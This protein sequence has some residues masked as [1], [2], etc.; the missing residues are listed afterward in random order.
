MES[1]R[2]NHER[3]RLEGSKQCRIQEVAWLRPKKVQSVALG[4]SHALVVT[5]DQSIYS[6]G[7][8]LQAMGHPLVT[9]SQALHI[10]DEALVEA[11]YAE[12][13][14]MVPA[15]NGLTS[16]DSIEMSYLRHIGYLGASP[17]QIRRHASGSVI[18]LVLD[19]SES[20]TAGYDVLTPLQY[21]R[22][23]REQEALEVS[24]S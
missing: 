19:A 14:L 13:L 23:L 16:T 11:A 9:Q 10:T 7:N 24:D 3:G 8:M 5:A 18:Q 21:L 20:S 15:L 1:N 4:L 17:E 6:W 12:D 22:H 2:L